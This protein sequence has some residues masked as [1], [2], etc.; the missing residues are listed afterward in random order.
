MSYLNKD[1]I[2]APQNS[3]EYKNG[4]EKFLDFA[5]KNSTMEVEG[6]NESEDDEPNE[7]EIL[8]PCDKCSNRFWLTREVVY[9]HLIVNQFNKRYKDWNF[10]GEGRIND[11]IK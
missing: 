11:C 8:C 4:I 5:F 10:H 2:D 7:P 3:D 1:W 6:G 9:N